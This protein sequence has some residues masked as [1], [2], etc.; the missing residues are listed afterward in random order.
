MCN[1]VCAMPKDKL[2]DYIFSKIPNKEI[3]IFA[4]KTEF[5]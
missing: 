1:P 4:F 3:F 2:L 5:S